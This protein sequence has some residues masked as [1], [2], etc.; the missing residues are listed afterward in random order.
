MSC[1]LHGNAINNTGLGFTVF[2]EA[3]S[4][5]TAVVKTDD[6]IYETSLTL[7]EVLN[8]TTQSFSISWT[9]QSLLF[10]KDGKNEGESKV[11]SSDSHANESVVSQEYILLFGHYY[12]RVS[13]TGVEL[14]NLR[15]RRKALPSP[16]VEAYGEINCKFIVPF[17]R[18]L[19]SF[20]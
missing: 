13:H 15:I 18:A 19:L 16:D 20:Y 4:K 7:Q 1:G 11:T 12:H 14:L 5:L 2:Y 8:T 3:T 9:P 17:Q 6:K 10:F